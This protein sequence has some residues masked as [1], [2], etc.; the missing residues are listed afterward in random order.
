M[1]ADIAARKTEPGWPGLLVD[2]D[3]F[4]F[5]TEKESRAAGWA[6]D[7]Q[8]RADGLY[9][10]IR[11][12]ASGKSDVEGGDFRFLSP[13]FDDK[14]AVPL[15]GN[16]YRVVRLLGLALT[17]KPNIRTIRALTNALPAEIP[18]IP[19]QPKKT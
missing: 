13:V 3:H 9:G 6:N 15:G 17:N 8:A 1:A 14:S 11:F 10:P 5:D 12:S 16:R 18:P 4:S 19:T 7:A 2:R